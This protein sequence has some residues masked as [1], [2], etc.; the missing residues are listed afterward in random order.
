[1]LLFGVRV[2]LV[3]LRVLREIGHRIRVRCRLGRVERLGVGNALIVRRVGRLVAC[4][5]PVGRLL[6]VPCLRVEGG[7]EVHLSPSYTILARG[8]RFSKVI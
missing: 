4:I 5:A 2:R 6:I 8:V 1:M 3:Q 7:V